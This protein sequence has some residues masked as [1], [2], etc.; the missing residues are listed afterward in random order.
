M[1]ANKKF[2]KEMKQHKQDLKAIKRKY[3]FVSEKL[4]MLQISNNAIIES[5][6]LLMQGKEQFKDNTTNNDKIY[7]ADVFQTILF[8]S[9]DENQVPQLSERIVGQLSELIILC[10]KYQYVMV[11]NP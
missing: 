7:T 9:Y 6:I 2:Q 10:E 1:G 3:Q 5:I 4:K 8:E 11:I